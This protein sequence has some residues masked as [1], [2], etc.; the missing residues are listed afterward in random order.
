MADKKWIQK[1]IKSDTIDHLK[2]YYG[3]TWYR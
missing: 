3:E 1:A 2:V